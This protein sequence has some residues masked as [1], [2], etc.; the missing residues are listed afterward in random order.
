MILG[1][2]GID[3]QGEIVVREQIGKKQW[4]GGTTKLK[5]Y[6]SWFRKLSYHKNHSNS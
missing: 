3:G 5:N 6:N 1:V 2:G 4:S